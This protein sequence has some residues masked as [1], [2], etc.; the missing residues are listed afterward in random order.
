MIGVAVAVVL[1]CAGSVAAVG[2]LAGWWTTHQ[3][4]AT[5]TST[6]TFVVPD[7][8]HVV[9]HDTAGNVTIVA[10]SARQIMVDI[11]KRATDT[12]SQLA[13]HALDAISVTTHATADGLVIDAT[14][15]AD[16][17][18][19]RQSV[20]LRIAMPATSD[21]QLDMT[22]GTA[23]L[24]GIT[25]H[26]AATMTAGNL[27]LRDMVLDGASRVSLNAGNADLRVALQPDAT[28]DLQV[29]TGNALLAL[30]QESPT[31]LTARTA[32]GNL[33]INGWPA[34]IHRAGAGASTEVY[35]KLAPQNHVHVTVDTGNV[36]VSAY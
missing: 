31:L 2:A 36:V 20:D 29:H 8:P 7:H 28:L 3:V 1:L 19:T 22:A 4:N 21:V 32:V 35:C 11:T 34:T 30:P 23:H 25:G 10:G 33:T 24:S 15:S 14:T 13:Q 9:V 6:L 18:L 26:L 17:P 5:R 27:N 16:H 12:S